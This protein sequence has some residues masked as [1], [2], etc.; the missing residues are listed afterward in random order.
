MASCPRVA[1]RHPRWSRS[2]RRRSRRRWRP[3]PAREG[4]RAF[5]VGEQVECLHH[6][7][8]LQLACCCVRLQDTYER[9]EKHVQK[10][11]RSA[12]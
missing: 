12:A 8:Q 10:C 2:G 4:R 7:R 5:E 6:Q 3:G 11:R 1:P 9:P